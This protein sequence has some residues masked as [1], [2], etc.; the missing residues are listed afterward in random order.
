MPRFSSR[1]RLDMTFLP[2]STENF[3]RFV[4]EIKP[5]MDQDVYGILLLTKDQEFLDEIVYNTL[6]NKEYANASLSRKNTDR[7][8]TQR[9]DQRTST[10]GK[11]FIDRQP[12][13]PVR[14]FSEDDFL[15][16]KG[17]MAIAKLLNADKMFETVL[18][19]DM[20]Q[21][22]YDQIC[23]KFPSSNR[24]AFTLLKTAL[25]QLKKNKVDKLTSALESAEEGGLAESIRQIFEEQGDLSKVQK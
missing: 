23:E 9:S 12:T 25:D 3:T 13:L 1:K 2:N 4:V 15:T 10:K 21:V 24:Q 11:S 8:R 17:V 5:K 19:L 18:H 16:E 22:Q 20:K 7:Q 6:L 14:Q